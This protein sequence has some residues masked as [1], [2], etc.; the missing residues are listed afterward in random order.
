MARS[1]RS[2]VQGA[3][4]DTFP[5]HGIAPDGTITGTQDIGGSGEHGFVRARDGTITTFDVPGADGTRPNGIN[6]NGTIMGFSIGASAHAF[7]RI[8]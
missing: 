4:N 8:P 7:V 5:A 2:M 3:V 6:P 1:P